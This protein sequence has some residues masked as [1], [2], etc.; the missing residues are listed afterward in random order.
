MHIIKIQ[1]R[2]HVK[3]QNM[4]RKL[5]LL[6]ALSAVFLALFSCGKQATDKASENDDKYRSDVKVS[7]IE[8]RYNELLEGTAISKAE[9]GYIAVMMTDIDTSLCEEYVIYLPSGGN[10]DQYGIFKATSEENAVKLKESIE[11]YLEGLKTGWMVEYSP[12][13]FTKLENAECKTNGL[14]VTYCV[15]NTEKRSAVSD[16]FGQALTK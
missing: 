4:K 9:E 16:A 12:D 11:K 3:M 1:T 10:A 14:Y 15:L 13:E 6:A 7:D 5:L 2:G 8:A